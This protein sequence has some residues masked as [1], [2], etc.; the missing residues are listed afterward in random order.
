MRLGS[1]VAQF[2]DAAL[3]HGHITEMALL[4]AATHLAAGSSF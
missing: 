2:V 3:I 1:I 4:P